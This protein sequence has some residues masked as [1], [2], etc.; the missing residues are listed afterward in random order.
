MLRQ[1]CAAVMLCDAQELLPACRDPYRGAPRAAQDM[2]ACDAR[3]QLPQCA[4]FSS[5]T[6]QLNRSCQL[7]VSTGA[8]SQPPFP[9][10][11]HRLYSRLGAPAI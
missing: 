4:G 6:S 3:V 10:S 5:G 2:L 11:V 8:A 9:R 7:G 1:P